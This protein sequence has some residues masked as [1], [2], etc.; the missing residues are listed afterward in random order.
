MIVKWKLLS[1]TSHFDNKNT[2]RLLTCDLFLL[3]C[4]RRVFGVIEERCICVVLDVNTSS[5]SEF[6]TYLHA[7][8]QVLKEQVMFIAKFNLIR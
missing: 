3:S 6:A 4:S 7:L 1:T 8:I 2:T 5:E